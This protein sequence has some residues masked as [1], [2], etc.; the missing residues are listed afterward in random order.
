MKHGFV[1]LAVA[2]TVAF[3]GLTQPCRA[4]M[5][6]GVILMHGKDSTARPMSPVGRLASYLRNNFRVATPDM[7]WVRD[8]FLN[9]TLEQAFAELD[10]V[11]AKLK[12]EGATRIV[13]G[14]HS[15]GADAALAYAA[16]HPGLA[17]VLMIAPGHRPD[18]YA[19]KNVGTLGQARALVKAG[20][21]D[22]TVSVFDINTGKRGYRDVRA[23]A[24]LSWFDPDG[25]MVM[26]NSARKLAPGTPVLFI[27]GKEDRFHPIGRELVYDR[28][29]PHPKSAYIVV[30]G[31][32]KA[33][34]VKGRKQIARWLNGL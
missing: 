34:P 5:Q 9:G 19:P 4:D 23:D 22:K 33:T 15:M 3:A 27:I 14:G 7:P 10:S 25:P 28:L 12:A 21:P 11:I 1:A 6:T 32:H 29:P 13:V 18:I 2:L 26:Q 31:G 16:E 24:A 30:E 17:G 8:N 20:T